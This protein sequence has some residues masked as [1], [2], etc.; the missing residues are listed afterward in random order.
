M[1]GKNQKSHL[2]V[3]MIMVLHTRDLFIHIQWLQVQ[4]PLAQENAQ[5][6]HGTVLTVHLSHML[7][8]CC[9]ACFQKE[10]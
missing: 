5:P 8:L 3:P 9:C 10:K 1:V 6:M 2:Q 4:T 7:M